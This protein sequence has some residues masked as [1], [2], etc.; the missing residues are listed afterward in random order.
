[1]I[2]IND[3]VISQY[4]N[5]PVICDLIGKMNEWIDPRNDIQL[6]YDNIFNVATANSG[7]LD[8]WGAIVNLKRTLTVPNE[9]GA[10]GFDSG[11]DDWNPFNQAPFVGEATYS[12]YR[13]EDEAYRALIMVKAMANIVYA[14][15]PYINQMITLLFKD[16]GRAYFRTLGNMHARY[17]FEFALEPF[18]KVIVQNL[19]PRPSG[20]FIDYYD[21]DAGATFGF[22]Q[23]VNLQPFN[24][25]VF[26]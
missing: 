20:V 18:E 21:V 2:N 4:A 13:L 6:F 8:I 1:M 7:G 26:S 5:S 12:E 23:S 10:F 14:T 22:K 11:L 15:A 25:G 9:D 17:T 24:Q 16:R 3:T 19:L